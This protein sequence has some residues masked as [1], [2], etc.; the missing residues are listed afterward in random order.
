MEGTNVLCS[1]IIFLYLCIMFLLNYYKNISLKKNN[2]YLIKIENVNPTVNFYCCNLLSSNK[3][4]WITIIELV[5]K[6]YYKLYEKNNSL[7]IKWNKQNI[8]NINNLRVSD[9]QKKIISYVNSILEEENNVMELNKLDQSIRS[10]CNYASM[11]NSYM[12][13]LKRNTKEIIG[14]LDRL[15]NYKFS[16]LCT[17]LYSFQI[18]YFLAGDIN[19]VGRL[20]ITLPFTYFT[21]VISDVLKNKIGILTKKKYILTFVIAVIISLITSSIWNSDITNNYLIFHFLM[22]IFTYLYPLLIIINIYSIKTNC[23]YKNKI[24]K[25]LIEQMNSIELKNS[26]NIDYLYLKVLKIKTD[27]KDEVIDKYFEILDL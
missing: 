10:D 15:N 25:G 27:D 21:I 8:S 24:Q 9:Y 12:I 2:K 22:G 20:L 19:F 11:I 13:D 14:D 6:K 1:F 18:F 5:D 16:I 23:A 26:K 17:F 3:L 4:F 7:Y